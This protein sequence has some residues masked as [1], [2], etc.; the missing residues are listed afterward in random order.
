M[1]IPVLSWLLDRIKS[2]PKRKESSLADYMILNSISDHNNKWRK[3]NP[4]FFVPFIDPDLFK[5]YKSYRW[6]Q[7]IDLDNPHFV[8][9]FNKFVRTMKGGELR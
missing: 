4:E 5:V 6:D 7:N 2:R 3:E 9:S 8:H 1:K